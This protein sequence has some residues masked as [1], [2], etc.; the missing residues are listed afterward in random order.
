[1]GR[2]LS[3]GDGKTHILEAPVEGLQFLPGEPGLCLQ[4]VQPFWLVA[5]RG[6]LQLTVAAVWKGHRPGRVGQVAQLLHLVRVWA[7]DHGRGWGGGTRL[8]GLPC[9]AAQAVHCTNGGTA[10]SEAMAA[11][12]P[13]PHTALLP[14][15]SPRVP[16]PSATQWDVGWELVLLWRDT[17]QGEERGKKA[18]RWVALAV[19]TQFQDHFPPYSPP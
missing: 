15:P 4:L 12:P 18:A 1:M 19:K 16:S 5:H 11:L 17:E 10:H 6:Q 3:W 13:A 2:G 7:P 9:V 8:S 14:H